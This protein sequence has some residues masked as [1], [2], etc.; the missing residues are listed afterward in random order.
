MLA[1]LRHRNFALVWV[2]G[3][4]SLIGDRALMSAVLPQLVDE[5]HLVSA[6]ALNALNNNIARLAG[7]PIGGLLLAVFGLSSVAIVDSAS[8]LIAAV[9]IALVSLPAHSSSGAPPVAEA[10]VS[11]WA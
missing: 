2:G 8:F 5:Q 6:N 9:L 4:I 1:T 3:L 11:A 7:P 10:T